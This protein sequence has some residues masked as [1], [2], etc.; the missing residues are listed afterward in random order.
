MSINIR[1]GFITGKIYENKMIKEI[2]AKSVLTKHS[3]IESWFMTHYGMNLYRGCTHNC[4]YCDGRAE[5]YNVEGEFGK[6][7]FVKINALELLSHEL[8]PERK[9]KLMPGSFIMLGGGVCDAYQPV[10]K[11]YKLAR[12]ALELILKY[13]HPVHILTKSTLVERDIDILQKIHKQRRV[14]VSFSFSSADERI[15]RI[16]EPGVPGPEERLETIKKMKQQGFYCGMFLMPVIP[17]I[18][19]IPGVL[20]ETVRKAKNAGIDFIIF[21]GMTLKEGRQKEHFMNVLTKHYPQLIPDYEKIY[22]KN[23]R[24]GGTN[25]EYIQPVSFH[26]NRLSGK[27]GIPKRIPPEIYSDILNRTDLTIVILEHLDYLLKLN[28]QKSPYGYSA[29]SISKLKEP[30]ENLSYDQLLDIKGVGPVTAKIIREIAET[31]RCLYYE[32]LLK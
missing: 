6:D 26:F 24:W 5:S 17:F 7:V 29:F 10:E 1:T 32:K 15:S 22:D 19:D 21:G 23:D 30:V 3:K 2:Q 11:Q 31:G 27:Y 20:E 13:N 16:F 28:E 12:G 14:I 4:V 8:N 18:T 9:R 25:Y